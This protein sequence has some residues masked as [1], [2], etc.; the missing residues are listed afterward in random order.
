MTLLAVGVSHRTAPLALRERVE[1]DERRAA[2]LLASL[3]EHPA[4]QEAAALSTCNRTELYLATNDAHGTARAATAE[5]ARAGGISHEELGGAIRTFHGTEAV[6]HLFR[7]AAGLDSM[8]LGEAEIQGQV[9][10]SYELALSLRT[11]GPIV[12]RLFQDALRTGKRVRTETSISR[13]KAS[14][15]SVAVELARRELGDLSGRH[16]LVIG[17]GKHGALTARALT[18]AG[19]RTVYVANRARDRAEDL[20]RRFGGSAVG[21]HELAAELRRCDLVLTCTSCPHRV[22][23]RR[24]LA[25]AVRGRSLVVVDTAVPRDVEPSAGELRGVTLYD[26]DA[27]QNEIARNVSARD[28]EARNAAPIIDEEVASFERWLAALDV[29]PTI[30]ALRERGRAAVEQ[31]LRENEPRWQSLNDDD[32][33]RVELIARAVISDFLHEPTM[34]LRQA[35]ERGS[36]SLYV[37]TVREL[38]GLSASLD[39]SG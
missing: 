39:A 38:F 34:R 8:V 22:L 29:V 19:V 23:T 36:S 27:I 15:A 26:L 20:A 6:R 24:D 21:F 31:A 35:G 25:A 16:A 30:S 11:S 10:R 2:D 12:N 32:R 14:V 13:H 9:R 37:Q 3:T 18:D 17:A 5:L 28:E 4:I 1:L 33:K 7:V